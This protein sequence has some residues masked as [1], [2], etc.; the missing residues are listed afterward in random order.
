MQQSPVGRGGGGAATDV[1]TCGLDEE[2]EGGAFPL[3][4][5][6]LNLTESGGEFTNVK[7]LFRPA[8]FRHPCQQVT[9]EDDFLPADF[10]AIATQILKNAKYWG[11][12]ILLRAYPSQKGMEQDFA[13]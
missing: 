6:L 8:A 9:C 7:Q 1:G 3:A 5:S 13:A 12:Q 4:A 2:E 11:S 10:L